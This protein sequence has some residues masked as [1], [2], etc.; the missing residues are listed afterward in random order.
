DVSSAVIVLDSQ[1]A[2]KKQKVTLGIRD[3]GNV[4]ITKGLEGGERVVTVG[5][6]GL[7]KMEEDDLPKTQILVQAPQLPDDHEDE[8][9]SVRN[10]I[11]CHPP[12]APAG[13]EETDMSTKL[14]NTTMPPAVH[15]PSAEQEDRY[16]FARHSKSIVF[17]IV[18]LAAVGIYEALSLPIA[19]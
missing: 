14:T 15:K 16:W 3:A 9:D 2:P 4:Q 19:V 13:Y 18:M 12:P 17:M 10:F 8:D 1:N 7:D 6:F 5:A 11:G